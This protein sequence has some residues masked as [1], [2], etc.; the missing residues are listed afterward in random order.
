HPGIT[1][2]TFSFPRSAW[3][4][5]FLFFTRRWL[6]AAWCR[7]SRSPRCCGCGC[8]LG[9]AAAM[10]LENPRRRELAQFVTHHVFRDEQ[11]HKL[12]AVMDHERMSDEIR[13]HGAIARPGFDRLASAALVHTFDAGQQA[14]VDIRSFLQRSAHGLIPS[15]LRSKVRSGAASPQNCGGG[16]V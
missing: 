2:S 6:G 3:E 12:F 16:R 5:G 1:L 11:P 15:L 10:P 7:R 13:N 9:L 8:R 4:R 14:L